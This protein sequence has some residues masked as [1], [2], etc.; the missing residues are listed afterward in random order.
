MIESHCLAA[1][2]WSK[3]PTVNYSIKRGISELIPEA[4]GIIPVRGND[5][6]KKSKHM[7]RMVQLMS[8]RSC[9]G[10][11]EQPKSGPQV[12]MED[13]ARLVDDRVLVSLDYNVARVI[14][15]VF[16]MSLGFLGSLL[17]SLL[18]FGIAGCVYNSCL[19][20]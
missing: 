14:N 13:T 5:T 7:D 10:H 20:I 15:T 18:R 6:S 4:R 9:Q 12:V 19:D 17:L 1:E 11:M 2:R 16:P 3:R 8:C